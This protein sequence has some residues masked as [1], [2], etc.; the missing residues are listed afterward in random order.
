LS[1]VAAALPATAQYHTVFGLHSVGIFPPDG[2][3]TPADPLTIQFLGVY[4]TTNTPQNV[5]VMPLG[6]G[7]LRFDLVRAGSF[8]AAI[9]TDWFLQKTFGPLPAGVYDFEVRGITGYG[10]PEEFVIGEAIAIDD[11]VVVVPEPATVLMAAI[12]VA[13]IGAARPRVAECTRQH[14]G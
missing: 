14:L 12:G 9:P 1:Y 7:V 2:F 4:G 10:T 3:A 13:V 11:F 5:L 8:G 6:P